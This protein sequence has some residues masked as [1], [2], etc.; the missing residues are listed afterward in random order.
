MKNIPENPFDRFDAW[1]RQAMLHNDIEDANA[2]NLATSTPDGIP[3]NRIVL[4]KGHN[5]DGFV[6]FTN[7]SSRKG[8]ELEANQHAAMC[9]YWAPLAMQIRIEGKV[10]SV[11]DEEADQYFASRPLRS[12]VGAWAS[13]QSRPLENRATLLKDVARET[14][15][16]ALGEVARPP[17]WS[18][19]RL[20]PARMEFWKN[21]EYRLHDRLAYTFDESGLWQHQLLYP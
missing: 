4:L 6:F 9:F 1:Y 15:R 13:R 17:F 2:V 20:V 16:F 10:V 7:L 19:F 5:P 21:G 18:G 3:S 12:R 11:I 8:K 14:A